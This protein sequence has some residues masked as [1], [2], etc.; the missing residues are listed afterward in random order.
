MSKSDFLLSSHDVK[1]IKPLLSVIE[2]RQGGFRKPH[3]AALARKLERGREV[4]A[5]A[6]PPDVVSMNSLIVV[7]SVDDGAR[8]EFRLVFPGGYD[9]YGHY[10]SIFSE[11]GSAVLGCRVGSVITLRQPRKQKLRV[12]SIKFQPEASRRFDL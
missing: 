6:L 8:Y 7:E 2:R 4:S 3:L 5:Q 11:L 10:V 9:T 1:R 12:H